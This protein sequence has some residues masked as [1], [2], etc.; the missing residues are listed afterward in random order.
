MTNTLI[1]QD[2]ILHFWLDH[3]E[4]YGS[5]KDEEIFEKLD[6]DNSNYWELSDYTFTKNEAPKYKYKIIFSKDNYSLFAYYKWDKNLKGH[7][8]TKDHITIYSTAFRLLWKEEIFSFLKEYLDLK[9]CRRF[10]ICLDLKI[11]IDELLKYF[12]NLKTGREYK[13]EWRMETRY[14]WQVKNSMNKRYIVRV[15]DKLKDIIEKKKTNLYQ[16]YLQEDNV[17]R[18]ELEIRPELAKNISYE[19]LFQ[20]SELIWI[21]KNYLWK[22]TDIFNQIKG[23]TIT[24]YGNKHEKID[25]ELYQWTYYKNFKRTVFLWHAKTIHNLWYCP[26]RVLLSEWYFTHKTQMVLWFD[27]ME[28]LMN[29]EKKLKKSSKDSKYIR[30]NYE[31]ILSNLY[32]YGKV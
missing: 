20:T 1:L 11:D 31:G 26:V 13:K 29:R 18:V 17:T 23:D 32:K 22:I 16:N 3:L 12:D 25:P 4:I 8:K 7:I 19:K 2:L 5:F 15:Y 9:H 6:Y 24:L 28:D 10:D 27:G 14:Y 21:Y 30:D